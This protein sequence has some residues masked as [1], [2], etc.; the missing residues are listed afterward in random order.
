MIK[1]HKDLQVW[2]K[3]KDLTEKIYKIT[4][5]IP[6]SEAYGITSQI[7]RSAVSISSNIAESAARNSRK[8]FI[9]FL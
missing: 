5:Q 7:R 4:E 6:K 1:T 2:K 9:Q 8:E 3:A